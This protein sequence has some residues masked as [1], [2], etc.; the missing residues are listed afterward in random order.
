MEDS[1][2]TQ[3][4]LSSID[5]NLWGNQCPLTVG[6]HLVLVDGNPIDIMSPEQA[7]GALAKPPLPLQGKLL[8]FSLTT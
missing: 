8:E 5:E 4:V 3:I 7:L 6:D 2:P 1:D